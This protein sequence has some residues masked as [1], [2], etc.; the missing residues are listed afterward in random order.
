MKNNILVSVIIP[1][2]NVEKYIS[3]CI[4]SVMNQ[5]YKN[6]EIILINDGSTDRS[7][8]ICEKYAA[9]DPRIQYINKNNEG[10][11]VARNKG[12]DVAK[13]DFITFIDADDYVDVDFINTVVEKI[14]KNNSDIIICGNYD[15]DEEYKVIKNSIEAEERCFNSED[16]IRELC[17]EK[18]FKSVIWGKCYKRELFNKYKFNK[19]TKIAE[20]LE[21]LYKVLS[22]AEIITYIPDRLYYWL[23]RTNSATKVSFN[24]DWEKELSICECIIDFC[25]I[26]YP[27][28]FDYSVRRYVRINLA[29]MRKIVE[30]D[31][32]KKEYI[33]LSKNLWKYKINDKKV[34]TFKEYRLYIISKYIP[35]ITRK[36]LIMKYTRRG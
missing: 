17:K 15:V 10:V 31:N 14:N 32:N 1:V 26:N 7:G 21:V 3:R 30:S 11:S 12:L 34:F 8:E 19:E 13:G 36:L 18:L 16:A 33:R 2:Y 24:S 29:L 4:D 20:D 25:K 9:R 35:R 23:S 28:I 5:K 6:I 27:N 22:E